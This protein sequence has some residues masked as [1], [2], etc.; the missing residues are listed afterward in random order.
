MVLAFFLL[1]PTSAPASSAVGVARDGLMA[2]GVP[3]DL[4]T[5]SRAEFL[6]NV[7]AFVPA[8][9][10]V[11]AVWPRLRW[12][13]CVAYGFL[14]SMGVETVQALFFT[15]R[16]ATMRDV[17]ANTTGAALGAGLGVW[18]RRRAQRG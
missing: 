3:G 7:A 17:V 18:L 6:T 2:L 14:A 9:T 16:S 15:G 13:D 5:S 10:L 11:M 1:L 12:Q 8:L 4:L